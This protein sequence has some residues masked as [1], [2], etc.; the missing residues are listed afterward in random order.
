M[1]Q[2]F[3]LTVACLFLALTPFG[4][5]AQPEYTSNQKDWGFSITPYALLAS[6]STDV[7]GQGLRQSFNDLTSLTNSGFQVI[8]SIRYKRLSFAFD[9]TFAE[10]GDEA[11]SGPL[12]VDF[13]VNQNIF[14]FKAGYSVYEN[15]EFGEDEILKGWALRVNL[16]AK[17]WANKVGVNF[18]ISIN[19]IIIDEGSLS[20]NQEWWDPMVGVNGRFIL[21]NR[22]ALIVDSNIGGFGL[23]N[24]SRF[25]YD[26]TY[27]NAFK[28][29]KLIV[30]DVGFRSFQYR[31]VDGS[32]EDELTTTVSVLSPVLGVSLVF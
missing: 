29:S 23:G 30:L 8:A 1:A 31:R 22:F 6:Q 9:G 32:D 15:F 3:L 21:S 13:T 19:D 10:L 18:F 20:E 4:Q 17:Y 2:Q 16:G 7:G 5:D 24:A 12:R 27:L 11:I 25:T 26:L 14:G 28:L